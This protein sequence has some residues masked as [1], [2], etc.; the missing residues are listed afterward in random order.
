MIPPPT[1]AIYAALEKLL[2]PA[3]LPAPWDGCS[4][5]PGYFESPPDPEQCLKQLQGQFSHAHLVAA[6]VLLAPACP[7][8]QPELHPDLQVPSRKWLALRTP[9]GPF[10]YLTDHGC[11]S[12]RLPVLASQDDNHVQ[13]LLLTTECELLAAATVADAAMLLAAG[14][15]AT[16]SLGL[17][18]LRRAA[19][20]DFCEAFHLA[21]PGQD[22]AALERP[23]TAG[24]PGVPPVKHKA[25]RFVIVA[26]SPF[27]LSLAAPGQEDVRRHLERLAH[28]LAIPLQDFGWWRPT[29][30][31]LASLAFAVQT[32]GP[33]A[34]NVQLLA[35]I[36][37]CPPVASSA[38]KKKPAQKP[39][40]ASAAI[41]P[42]QRSV[43]NPLASE[44]HAARWR[45]R[46]DQQVF[47]P[48][49][50]ELES[51]S[52]PLTQ[53][54]RFA[55]FA[56]SVALQNY[57]QRVVATYGPANKTLDG[58]ETRLVTFAH[59]QVLVDTFLKLTRALR[60]AERADKAGKAD[61]A[62]KPT[63]TCS[64]VASAMDRQGKPV[65]NGS[66]PG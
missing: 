3:T 12:G 37:A 27:Q 33:A 26:W 32:L 47:G 35:S 65:G 50:H 8:A 45:E 29:E 36:D 17:T 13:Q 55:H 46:L 15:P 14:L 58:D 20:D 24:K 43:L 34:L 28:H 63:G 42:G 51:G 56:A 30:E 1:M 7:D 57:L 18:Q 59:L 23:T 44:Q 49:Q 5:P 16:S 25:E 11:L 6:G 48:L 39:A 38:Q 66:S 53:N 4:A 22:S 31:E 41:Q 61:K 40:S 60:A 54:L 62:D 52:C 9:S 21:R 10:D 19:L 2:V 64:R